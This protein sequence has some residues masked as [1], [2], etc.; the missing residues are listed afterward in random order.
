MR[1]PGRSL[2]KSILERLGGTLREQY[3]A[4]VD[5]DPPERM[6]RLLMRLRLRAVETPKRG[7]GGARHFTSR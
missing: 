4:V 1:F 6:K 3:D 2:A 7:S 5:E